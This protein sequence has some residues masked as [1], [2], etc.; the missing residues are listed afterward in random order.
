MDLVKREFD[1]PFKARNWNINQWRT[2]TT[3]TFILQILQAGVT[4]KLHPNFQL[5]SQ[6]RQRKLP[7]EQEMWI[8]QEIQTMLKQ[9]V[10]T[11]VPTKLLQQI[12]LSPI[13]LVPK[14]NEIVNGQV[15]KK[16]RFIMDLRE[17]N[18]ATIP[19]SS[20]FKIEGIM[21]TKKLLLPNQIYS[22]VDLSGAFFQVP[23]H[24]SKQK[25]FA[26]QHE[27]IQ[28]MYTSLPFGWKLSPI[29]FV[30]ISEEIAKFLRAV[31]V[32]HNVYID[33]FLLI[34][35]NVSQMVQSLHNTFKIFKELGVQVNIKKVFLLQEEMEF[36]GWLLLKT[37]DISLGPDK[38]TKV[39]STLKNILKQRVIRIKQLAR[40]VGIVAFIAQIFRGL[41]MYLGVMHSRI[42]SGLRKYGW[43]AL[44]YLDKGL[45]MEMVRL[46]QAIIRLNPLPPQLLSPLYIII[47][48]ASNQ[49]Y[50]GLVI[51]PPE[52]KIRVFTG[53]WTAKERK[54]HIC[55]L[56]LKAAVLTIQKAQIQKS[57]ITIY[58][59]NTAT[60]SALKK[61]WSKSK[62]LQ[63]WCRRLGNMLLEKEIV[64]DEVC[65]IPTKANPA[66][67]LTR[68]IKSKS[69]HDMLDRLNRLQDWGLPQSLLLELATIQGHPIQF[70]LFAST[71]NALSPQHFSRIDS[72]LNFLGDVFLNWTSSIPGSIAVPPLSLL[73]YKLQVILTTPKWVSSSWWTTLTRITKQILQQ[74]IPMASLR[75]TKASE[76]AKNE[77]WTFCT[78]L[79][80]GAMY[81]PSNL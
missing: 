39:L 16:Y 55:T 60:K 24:V 14:P 35:S 80:N 11:I 13:F 73:K 68:N 29:F 70:D 47:I 66:D 33:D 22:K 46:Q 17:L 36:L 5:R 61:L 77:R 6:V 3:N 26:F 27:N 1:Y 37:G 4:F 15:I 67:S 10:I 7:T 75:F 2:Y 76:V 63:P 69:Y 32:N 43:R 41:N 28:Y 78:R 30:Q 9:E 18:S 20:T 74:K 42:R 31:N 38:K 53:I 50:C 48:D 49:G 34:E 56:E 44:I 23:I 58:T 54:V 12:H 40:L 62:K 8:R 72:K 64:I 71:S 45:R 59:D 65:Y 57:Y 79:V 52:R 25:Y 19:I 51:K 81:Y 21:W